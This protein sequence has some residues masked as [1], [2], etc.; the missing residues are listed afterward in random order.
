MSLV[1]ADKEKIAVV[2]AGFMG[3][4]IGQVFA[5][6]GHSVHI[7][8]RSPERLKS[9]HERV[10]CNLSQ[11]ADYG[12]ADADQIPA[13]LDRIALTTD[14]AEACDGASL[15]IESIPESPELKQM[16]FAELDR[17]CAPDV[18]LCSNT[19]VISI[20]KIGALTAHPER[21]LGTHFYQPPFLVPLVEVVRTEVTNLQLM[22]RVF[23]ILRDAGKVP[24]YV[25]K[26]V[27]GFVANR[28]QHA[29]W[30]E[31]F[32]L[33]DNGV[34]DAETVDIAVSNSFGMRLPVL[35]PVANADFVG[36]DLTLA[37]HN[38]VLQHLDV[39]TQPSAT[40]RGHVEAGELGFKTGSGFLR[41][42]DQSIAET[43]NNLT[44][45]LLEFLS[46]SKNNVSR[47]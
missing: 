2:G 28:M 43:R 38:N 16:L 7:Y 27:P 6:C 29:L 9:V 46:K 3:P 17:I 18:C 33:I 45:Y 41:W 42:D 4:G 10:R 14:I 23:N 44:Q 19:S 32:A 31:A 30:R 12:L 35:G 34:C 20:R 22:D 21:V 15:V 8:N 36:L 25:R 47:G 11:M 24:I 26:D 40:L 5:A 39:S 1:P 37:I 13:I